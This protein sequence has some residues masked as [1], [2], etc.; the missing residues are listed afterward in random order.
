MCPNESD[1]NEIYGELDNHD[2]A[3]IVP[4]NI[5]DIPLVSNGI[6]RIERL[7][8]ICKTPPLAVP[9]DIFPFLQVV[10][11]DAFGTLFVL[12]WG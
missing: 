7:F 12:L 6:D 5:E 3:V 10:L 1:I 8:D 4:H 11:P 9:D 2:N